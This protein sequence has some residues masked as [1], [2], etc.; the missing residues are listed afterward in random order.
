VQIVLPFPLY[1]FCALPFFLPHKVISA[2]KLACIV[3]IYISII[4]FHIYTTYALQFITLYSH[5]KS[6]Y[7]LPRLNIYAL[8]EVQWVLLL[9]F[10]TMVKDDRK[11]TQRRKS[12]KY[13]R[14]GC[15]Y[16]LKF[17]DLRQAKIQGIILVYQIFR[18]NKNLHD[19]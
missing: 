18:N 8:N 16:R 2:L 9:C 13:Y 17:P 7:A 11:M 4:W 5:L 6:K 15:T 12:C 19:S 1:L 14:K 10:L 3:T